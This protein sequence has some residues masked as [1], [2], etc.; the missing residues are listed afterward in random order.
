MNYDYIVIGAGTAG[1][2]LAN[3]LSEDGNHRVLLLE[4]GGP[5]KHEEIHIPAGFSKLFKTD[6]D[7]QYYT[8]PEEHLNDRRIYWPRGKVIG[9]SGSINAMIYIRGH[10]WDYNHWAELGNEEWGYEDVLPYF[11]KSE[12]QTRGANKFHNV[13]GVMQVT[14]PSYPNELSLAFVES[15][16]Q[17]G[18]AKNPDF[19]G[20]QF[21]GFGLYQVTQ[22]KTARVSTAVAFLKPALK[23]KNLTVETFAQVQKVNINQHKAESVTYIQNGVVN[24]VAA[25]KEVV[26]CGGAINSPQLLMLSGIGPAKHLAEI[27]IEIAKDLPGV[28]QNLQDHLAVA[29]AYACNEPISIGNAESL[30]NKLIYK[31]TKRGPLTSNIGE[32]GG[33][34]KTNGAEHI[35]DIQ[36]IFAPVYYLDHGFELP[37]GHGFTIVPILLR[38]KSIGEIKLKTADPLQHPRIYANYCTHPE[39][40]EK[41]IAGVRTARKI[42][43]TPA[44][45]TYE[46][47]ELMPGDEIESDAAIR[48][49]IRDHAFTLYHP[50]GT[51][52]MGLDALSVVNPQLQVHGIQGLRVA[53]ASIM[54]KIISGNTNAPTVMIAEKAADMI[55]A[56]VRG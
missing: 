27:G 17:A 38:P 55:L 32:A 5:D 53:D 41:M 44:L 51:C 9:G 22:D 46:E 18:F 40:M 36:L 1:C 8:E 56:D 19:N 33:F 10:A 54:P 2:V 6:V 42:A 21:E 15:C 23:R 50:V 47:G 25:N 20:E 4:A 37:E 52:K 34:F 31:I 12:N 29:V 43:K 28:G 35:P 11:L 16:K 14:D 24:T 30:K 45:A 48:D 39:D 13:G 26:L 7:W 3:R 49:Y